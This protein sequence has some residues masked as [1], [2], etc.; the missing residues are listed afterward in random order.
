MT[1]VPA[2]RRDPVLEA[3]VEKWATP[4]KELIGKLPKGGQQL[5]YLGH[6]DVTKALLETDLTWSWEPV[7]TNEAGEPL[8]VVREA[9]ARMWIRLTV[10]GVT[11][12]GVG[13]CPAATFDVEKQL[14]GDAIR[15][16]AMRFGV[17]LSLWSKQEWAEHTEPALPTVPEGWETLEEHD[18]WRHGVRLRAKKLSLDA[19]GEFAEWWRATVKAEGWKWPLTGDQ[20]DMYSA[21][22]AEIEAADQAKAP[23]A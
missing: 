14:I 12:L 10:C 23:A 20:A 8:I 16:A 13:T 22:L 17:A 21:K 11:R 19:Q 5:D 7:A 18:A 4:P 15:N 2:V 1:A 9:T 6:A 3:L